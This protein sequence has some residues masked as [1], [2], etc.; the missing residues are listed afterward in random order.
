MKA[1]LASTANDLFS[2]S[3]RILIFFLVILASLI[4]V[5]IFFYRNNRAAENTNYWVRHTY[6]VIEQTLLISSLS[7][8][9][10]W[11]HR[12]HMRSTEPSGLENYYKTNDSLKYRTNLLASLAR[13]NPAQHGRIQRL[14]VWLGDLQTF[15]DSM[16]LRREQKVL[17]PEE[18]ADYIRRQVVFYTEINNLLDV[19]R[20]EESHLLTQREATNDHRIALTNQ[21]FLV[22]VGLL[23]LLLILTFISIYYYFDK[24]RKAEAERN[25]ALE[26]E[27]ELNQMKSNFVS[28]ASHE[29]R[30]PL[31]T[32]LSSVSLLEQY[33]TTETQEKRDKHIQRIKISVRELVAT[34]EEFLSLEK[35]E[36]GKVNPI[37]T[38]FNLREQVN[39]LCENFRSVSKSGHVIK[40]DHQGEEQ[41]SL[42][43][44]FI[45]HIITNLVSNAV[46]YSP[47]NSVVTITTY[48]D[49][50]KVQ[51]TVK[52]QG[53]GISKE[54]QQHLFERFFRASN[55][56]NI[57][58]TGLG[59][60][61]IKR[62]VE[63]LGGTIAVKSQLN[64]GAEF[65]ITLPTEERR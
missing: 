21:F 38:A 49:P 19:I 31:S 54:D 39:L 23:F 63:L 27:K 36:E 56:G 32:I 2:F 45:D 34:L 53:I 15:C 37:R 65:M 47:E 30:T 58:G 28:L 46:K 6:D 60:H 33:R 61:I 20:N 57:K 29:F 4:A 5:C 7:K 42:D 1:R 12:N 62:Y 11:E 26:K 52:D 16:N 25:N 22:V 40:Y 24:T 14:Q 59:L 64:E 3:K 50:A 18:F 51:L 8:N 17:S 10:Q 13:D 55:T 48:A 9:L 35:I 43:R 41:V 44:T